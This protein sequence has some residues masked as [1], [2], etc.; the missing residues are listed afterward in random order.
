MFLVRFCILFLA[1]IL[2][3]G[4]INLLTLFAKEDLQGWYHTSGLTNF[5]CAVLRGGTSHLRRH[6]ESCLNRTATNTGQTIIGV[7]PSGSIFSFTFNQDR[8]RREIVRYFVREELPFIKVDKPD[9]P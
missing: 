6:K 7:G 9:F 1:G 4:F 8:A 5:A 3:Y 2:W